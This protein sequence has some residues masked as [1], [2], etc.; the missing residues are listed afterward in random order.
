VALARVGLLRQRE[1][2]REFRINSVEK[3]K[4]K[5]LYVQQNFL[6]GSKSLTFEDEADR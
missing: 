5:V 4:C 6:L 1:K 3:N 2:K